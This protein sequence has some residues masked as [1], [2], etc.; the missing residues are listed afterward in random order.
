MRALSI[1]LAVTLLAPTA[2][3]GTKSKPSA[4][5]SRAS[6]ILVTI[7][8]IAPRHLAPFGGPKA[9]PQLAAAAAAG[10]IFDD[11]MSTAP[12]ARPALVSLLAGTPPDRSGVRDN[13]HDA[14][15]ESVAT[16][17]SGAK[18]SGFETA[19]FVASSFAS[20][21]S[22]LQRGFELFDGPEVQVIGPAQFCTPVVAGPQVAEHF[23]QWLTTRQ[24]GKPFFAWIHLSDLNCQATQP[25]GS[26][27]SSVR[28]SGDPLEDYDLALSTTDEAI[29]G[30]LAAAKADP[31]A[32]AA[33]LTLVGTHSPYLG[34]SGRRGDGFWLADETLRV[35]LVRL[36]RTSDPPAAQ[37]KHDARPTWL[38]DISASLNAALGAEVQADP[39]AIPLESVA[40]AGRLRMAWAYAPDDQLAWPPLTAVRDG[41][42]L[43]VFSASPSGALQAAGDASAE[44]TTAA[45]ARP[46]LPRQRILS[47]AD[48]ATI[49][50]HGFKLGPGG[51]VA[52]PPKNAD[53]W[54]RDLQVSRLFLSRRRPQLAGRATLKLIDES[55]DAFAALLQRM[56][57]I[58]SYQSEEGWALRKKLLSLYPERSDV[59]HWAAHLSLIDKAYKVAADILDAAIRVG[60]VEPEIY[61][62]RACVYAQQGRTKEAVDE[63][64]VA[65]RAG[66]RNWDWFDKDPDMAPIRSAPEFVELLRTHGR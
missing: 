29:G 47:D 3:D 60:P 53:D 30:I 14:I 64:A 63:L 31:D 10:T 18:A 38:P 1:T 11:V 54:L 26:D 40:P 4:P 43:T 5:A 28:K 65:I 22:G 27:G 13:I 25:P 49:E 35:P 48:R 20:Y 15:P 32:A 45:K 16:L 57:Q 61:Y 62:D 2:C 34:E 58:S 50:K 6:Q 51:T 66:Y 33:T 9:M 55:P 7:E 42:G 23:K 19:A 52:T 56:I 8:A 39:G 21:S 24:K 12:A 44:V 37:P 46:A 17:A 41:A 59:L 36:A